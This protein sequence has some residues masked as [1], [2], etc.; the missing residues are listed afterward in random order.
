M[1][2]EKINNLY[3]LIKKTA[4][5]S[6]CLKNVA[7]EDK[8]ITDEVWTVNQLVYC[9][10][11]IKDV[12]GYNI[13]IWIEPTGISVPVELGPVFIDVNTRAKKVKINEIELDED[14]DIGDIYGVIAKEIMVLED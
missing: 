7:H 12:Y 14:E 13:C 8:E 2:Q 6:L 1:K 9:L 10:E 4:L 3:N 5:E 11:S